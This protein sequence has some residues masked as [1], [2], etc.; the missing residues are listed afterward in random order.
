MSQRRL[1]GVI[2]FVF[3]QIDRTVAPVSRASQV[4]KKRLFFIVSAS[5]AFNLS[6]GGVS[7][8]WDR[9]CGAILV[10]LVS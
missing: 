8:L 4:L 10:L 7:S 3:L 2:V 5:I 1:V 9:V 6:W